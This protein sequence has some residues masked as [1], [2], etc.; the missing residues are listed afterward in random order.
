M[1]PDKLVKA[2]NAT[3]A[4]GCVISLLFWVF[5]PLAFLAIAFTLSAMGLLD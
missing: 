3:F 2:G 5:I 1:N 4:A